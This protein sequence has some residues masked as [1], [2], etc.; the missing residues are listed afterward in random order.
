MS[1]QSVSERFD[2]CQNK[3]CKRHAG[4][5]RFGF[6]IQRRKRKEIEIEI[7]PYVRISPPDFEVR[8]GGLGR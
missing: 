6:G 8:P 1:K 2:R 7:P 5:N 4:P 3:P